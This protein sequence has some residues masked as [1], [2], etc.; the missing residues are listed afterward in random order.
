VFLNEPWFLLVG[1]LWAA[2]GLAYVHPARRRAW[3]VSAGLSCLALSV[4]GVLS[5]LDVIGSV[6]AG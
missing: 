5:G 1:L 3:L 2:L 4:I 6:R